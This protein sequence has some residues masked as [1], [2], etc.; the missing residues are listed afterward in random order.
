VQTAAKPLVV[1]PRS[2][3]LRFN[4]AKWRRVQRTTASPAVWWSGVPPLSLWQ[5]KNF[6]GIGVV[7]RTQD[8]NTEGA[9]KE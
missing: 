6:R 7:S 4:A 8:E 2:M 3:S 5:K 9:A 1:L